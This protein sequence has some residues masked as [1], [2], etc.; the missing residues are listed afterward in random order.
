MKII[1]TGLASENKILQDIEKLKNDL[2][3][4]N[5]E[6]EIED[7]AHGSIILYVYISETVFTSEAMFCQT[8][9]KL[10]RKLLTFIGT[11]KSQSADV[12]VLGYDDLLDSGITLTCLRFIF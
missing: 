12:V 6:I 2:N 5:Y 8:I 7:I 1:V 10:L 11:E 3:G 4:E 9:V